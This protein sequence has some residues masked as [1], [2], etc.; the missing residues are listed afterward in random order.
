MFKFFK[1]KLSDVVKK[2]SKQVEEESEIVEEVKEV[3]SVKKTPKV[4]KTKAVKETKQK[5]EKKSEVSKEE[6]KKEEKKNIELDKATQKE[7]EKINGVKITYFV[8]GTTK[9]NEK[10]LATGWKPGELST[11]GVQQSKEL[12]NKIKDLKF[13]VVFCSDLKRAVDSAE[14]SFKNE[15]KIIKDKRLREADYG[16]YTLTSSADFKDKLTDFVETPFPNGESYKQVKKRLAEFTNYLFENHY[17]EHVAIV[18]HQA[19]QLALDVLLTEK[20]WAQAIAEDWR[21]KKAWRPGWE[22][23]ISKEVEVPEIKEQK[24]EKKGFFSKIFGKKEESKDD[25]EELEEVQKESESP[26][27]KEQEKS[28]EIKSEKPKETIFKKVSDSFTKFSLS[29]EKF[30]ELFWDLE[31][32]L[33]ENNVAVEVIQKIKD[34]LREELTKDKIS[35]KN[36][37]EIIH[38]SLVKSL[39]EVLDVPPVDLISEIKKKKPYVIA[40]IGVNGSGKTTTIAKLCS[41]L[42]NDGFSIVLAA[43]DT[44]RAAAIQQLEEHANKLDIKMIKHDYNSD[45]AAVAFDAV[46]HAE[47]KNLD[48]VI[49]DTA[50]RLH[51]NDNL[52]NELKKLIRVN[53]PDFKLFVGESITGNDCVE[54]AKKY[55]ELIGIDGIILSKADVDEKGG[56]ALSISYITKK[57]VLFIGTGQEYKDLKEFNKDEII[58]N[59]GF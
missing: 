51:S 44:F 30:E 12:P 17:G 52:M 29:D 56:A 50:G 11:L 41:K 36:P 19:P 4:E 55:N 47:S 3:K 21:L 33:L 38:D 39:N 9:D 45:P 43:A 13:D 34:D 18:A 48:V 26:K 20:T 8:H 1:E 27:E 16:D 54:Q 42:K 58:K 25:H 10:D 53:K 57:P 23:F 7:S 24:E 14:L 37:Q 2:F 49:I 5:V 15:Y 22:Y 35:R 59:L 6:I 32:T 46:R 31:V 40:V 28:P